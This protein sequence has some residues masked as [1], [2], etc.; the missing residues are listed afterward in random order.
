Q[1]ISVSLQSASELALALPVSTSASLRN[2]GGGAISAGEMISVY[3]SDGVTMQSAFATPGQ[4]SPPILVRLTSATTYDILDNSNPASPS[5]L[6]AGLT[7]I[8]GQSNAVTINGDNLVAGT[9][10]GS[11]GGGA[12][13]TLDYGTGNETFTVD[14]N[15]SGVQ[16]ITLATDYT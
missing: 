15:G 3:Q 11:A 8:P 10:S 7:F 13:A 1:S 2:T 12:P 6:Q 5:M 9:A 4:L 16:N 14:F